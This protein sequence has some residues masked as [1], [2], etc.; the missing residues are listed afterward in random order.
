MRA[1]PVSCW[2]MTESSDADDEY[3]E[4]VRR[5][6]DQSRR[7]AE[8]IVPRPDYPVF[9]LAAPILTPAVLLH[10][11]SNG[12]PA[13]VALRYGSWET[14][15]G[16][17]VTV[18]SAAPNSEVRAASP[19]PGTAASFTY[20]RSA[21]DPERDLIRELDAERKR[22]AV[23]AEVDPEE[24]AE[25]P[26]FTR[27]TLPAG[28]AL[29]CRHGT[30]WAARLIDGSPE[31]IVTISGHGTDPDAVRLEPVTDLE[32]MLAARG[33]VFAR[34]RERRR[35]AP[36]P[37]LEPAEG[38]AA[39]RALADFSLAANARIREAAQAGREPRTPVGSGPMY[40]ALWQRAVRERQR[41]AGGTAHL[42]DEAVT[43]V[44][45]HL[46][47]LDERAA[48]FGADARLRETAIDQTLRRALLADSVPSE[49]AQRAWDRYWSEHL[50]WLRVDP[51]A[52]ERLARRRTR[53][54][55]AE[56]WLLAWA[57][58]AATALAGGGWVVE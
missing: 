43:A 29:V 37:V 54:E 25:P 24:P 49:P 1:E 35:A 47:H 41:L 48:W 11:S 57:D 55:L 21:R 27:E 5:L 31:V 17:H 4:W 51:D 9:G 39:W 15:T 46:G 26:R 30:M 14:A 53:E 20:G 28:D 33:E 18:T 56:D 8:S 7:D 36:P 38:V 16:P 13:L 23:H 2:G 22:V 3:R 42:A 58:W 52:A 44:I 12:F 32:P 34:L 45:N 40:A 10:E 19:V 6:R 50:A